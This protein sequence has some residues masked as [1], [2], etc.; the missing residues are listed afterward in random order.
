MTKERSYWFGRRRIGW[1]IG[2]TSWQ[3]W[4]TI[5]VY[6]ALLIFVARAGFFAAHPAWSAASKVIFTVGMFA[7][8]LAKF[9]RS[10][11]A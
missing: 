1:G 2:P 6:C 9:D 3:G 11:R 5:A 8:M 7:I 4:A 10:K